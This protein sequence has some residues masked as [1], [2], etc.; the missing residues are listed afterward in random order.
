MLCDLPLIYTFLF[1]LQAFFGYYL[2]K[3]PRSRIAERDLISDIGMHN[4]NFLC[5]MYNNTYDAQHNKHNQN[6]YTCIICVVQF[7][8]LLNRPF[9]GDSLHSGFTR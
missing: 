5:F 1:I 4:R 9:A 8:N 6:N 7:L 2:K 3:I